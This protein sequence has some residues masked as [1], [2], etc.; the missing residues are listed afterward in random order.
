M[1]VDDPN[2]SALLDACGVT[3]RGD[4]NKITIALRKTTEVH[5]SSY[6]LPELLQSDCLHFILCCLKI[7]IHAMED[8]G[9]SPTNFNGSNIDTDTTALLK[10]VASSP[11]LFESTF[12]EE[13]NDLNYTK[14]SPS[15]FPSTDDESATCVHPFD[16]LVLTS[17]T[18]IRN[19]VQGHAL[20]SNKQVS[21]T[22]ALCGTH[23][24]VYSSYCRSTGGYIDNSVS[25]YCR[26]TG[27]YID[28]SVNIPDK[29]CSCGKWTLYKFP[30]ACAI[31]VAMKQGFAPERFVQENCHSSYFIRAEILEEI[32]GR[33][34]IIMAPTTD[35]LR[36]VTKI[37]NCCD[38]SSCNP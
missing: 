11:A 24:K 26:S 9:V 34:K 15:S 16:G 12:A 22:A 8:P 1:A 5:D 35:Q 25:S 30:C 13:D 7:P 31:A 14:Q 32:A 27:G 37:C 28:N 18:D 10:S 17:W 6:F 36:T 3:T 20:T 2:V 29:K 21:C 19:A 38:M 23:K 33:L 4:R